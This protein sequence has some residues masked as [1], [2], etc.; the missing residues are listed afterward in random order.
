MARRVLQFVDM[1]QRRAGTQLAMDGFVDGYAF[2]SDGRAFAVAVGPSERA[3][4][5]RVMLWD[6]ATGTTGVKLDGATP[7]SGLAF[8]PH[9]PMLAVGGEGLGLWSMDGNQLWKVGTAEAGRVRLVSFSPDGRTL[10]TVT[11]DGL[12]RLWQ[13]G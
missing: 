12:V 7:F 2:S 10:A 9:A 6:P 1:T 4:N 11:L 5:G 8:A 13:V 3:P